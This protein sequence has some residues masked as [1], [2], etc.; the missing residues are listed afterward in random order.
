MSRV[1]Q[2]EEVYEHARAQRQRC[3]GRPFTVYRES[4]AGSLAKHDLWGEPTQRRLACSFPE[5]IASLPL[6]HGAAPCCRDKPAGCRKKPNKA[7]A[8]HGPTAVISSRT[9]WQVAVRQPLARRQPELYVT[10]YQLPGLARG[11]YEDRHT[12]L[13][14]ARPLFTPSPGATLVVQVLFWRTY[15]LHKLGGGTG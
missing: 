14:A 12:Y 7:I 6:R 2:P 15:T 4:A 9:L 11:P 5:V 3:S 1:R 10:R 8:S 13:G